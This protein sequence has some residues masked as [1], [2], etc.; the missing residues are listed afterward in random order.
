MS[1]C[2]WRG[3]CKCL[4]AQLGGKDSFWCIGSFL[5]S[6]WLYYQTENRLILK[7]YCW[8]VERTIKTENFQQK[9]TEK[10][11]HSQPITLFSNTEMFPISLKTKIVKTLNTSKMKR[12]YWK[13]YQY[14]LLCLKVC[15]FNSKNIYL[16]SMLILH[17]KRHIKC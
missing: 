16:Q 3:F 1:L 10:K 5:I 4:W 2:T 8:V 12:K 7:L 6:G 9:C 13:V 11:H 14:D 15:F 17:F